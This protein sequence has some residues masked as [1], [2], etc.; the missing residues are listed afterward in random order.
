MFTLRNSN[1]ATIVVNFSD[2]LKVFVIVLRQRQKGQSKLFTTDNSL[3]QWF[4]TG[5][6]RH[7]R[8]PWRGVRGAAKCLIYHIFSFFTTKGAQNCHF[9]QARVP[10]ILSVVQD[11]VNQKRL[12]NTAL[13]Y[14][15]NETRARTKLWLESKS[16]PN[17][18]FEVNKTIKLDQSPRIKLGSWYIRPNPNSKARARLDKPLLNP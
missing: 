11:A 14:Y 4:P 7:T 5:V 17:Y 9:S 6:P 15:P 16:R 12:E 2:Y 18:K 1:S 8:V 13:S 10:K 3:S